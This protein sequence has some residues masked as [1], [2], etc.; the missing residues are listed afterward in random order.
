MKTISIGLKDTDRRYLER[1]A[2]AAGVTVGEY[3]ADLLQM[4]IKSSKL[5]DV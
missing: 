2:R 5:L 3:I 1:R 4:W